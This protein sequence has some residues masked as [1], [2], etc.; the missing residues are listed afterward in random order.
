ME[1]TISPE[2]RAE[3]RKLRRQARIHD[4]VFSVW[5]VLTLIPKTATLAWSVGGLWLAMEIVRAVRRGG[6]ILRATV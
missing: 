6:F 1:P 3:I 2:T 4:V 5:L